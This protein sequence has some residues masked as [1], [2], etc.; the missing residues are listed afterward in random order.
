MCSAGNLLAITIEGAIVLKQVPSLVVARRWGGNFMACAFS[1]AGG[2]LWTA[3][4]IDRELVAIEV[5]ET[6]T[7]EV[8]ARVDLE[9]PFQDSLFS[10][11]RD[12]RDDRI[13]I[14]VAAGQDGQCLFWA[15]HSGSIIRVERFSDLTETTPPGFDLA[16]NRFLTVCEGDL[17]LY[18]YPSG[19]ELGRMKWPFEDDPAG[20]I[21]SFI[22]ENHGLI[23][24][25]DG[26]LFLVDLRQMKAADE[27][28][29]LGHEPNPIRELYPDLKCET[30][31]ISDLSFFINLPDGNFLSVHKQLPFRSIFDWQDELLIW[32]IPHT[33]RSEN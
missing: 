32:R 15:Q 18:R 10:F 33:L 2:L 1:P 4:R 13:A 8:L 29:I 17:R 5:R 19:P 14:W 9:D 24:S 28:I 30:G 3:R 31:L 23:H 11:F 7:W 21:A 27:V 25:G 12:P 22:G 20:E 16:G 26:R 6:T